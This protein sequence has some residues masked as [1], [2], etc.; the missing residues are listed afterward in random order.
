MKIYF[1]LIAIFLAISPANA[2]MTE[3]LPEAMIYKSKPSD[4]SNGTTL[5]RGSITE[6]LPDSW[7]VKVKVLEG[8]EDLEGKVI[9]VIPSHFSS[10]ATF[11]REDGYLAI[12]KDTRKES[13]EKFVADLFERSWLDWIIDLFGG[14]PYY[15]ASDRVK[16]FLLSLPE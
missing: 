9:A 13:S 16:P 2:C 8:P 6:K 1:L 4:L 10:C 11:G 3:P 15:F 5:I 14:E 12:K 7:T